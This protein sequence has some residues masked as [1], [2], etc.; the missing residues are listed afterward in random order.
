MKT[1]RRGK[2]ASSISSR[3]LKGL[4]PRRGSKT[5]QDRSQEG[6]KGVGSLGLG[7]ELPKKYFLANMA[8]AWT[9]L[10]PQDGPKLEPKLDK[11]QSEH[12]L[13]SQVGPGADFGTIFD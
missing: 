9:Q 10:G 8:P 7:R 3:I 13:G 6:P 5:L 4:A 2:G 1:A 12:G 11:N